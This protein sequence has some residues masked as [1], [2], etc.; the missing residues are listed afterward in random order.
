MAPWSQ[1]PQN[2]W[3]LLTS[4]LFKRSIYAG[5]IVSFVYSGNI[6]S[7][8]SC[9]P[10]DLQWWFSGEHLSFPPMLLPSLAA[11]LASGITSLYL[12]T[13]YID[14]QF[15]EALARSGA[16][17]TLQKLVMCPNII[18]DASAASFAALSQLR[19]LQFN[20][21]GSIGLLTLQSVAELPNIEVL[22]IF[23]TGLG[24]NVTARVLLAPQALPNLRKFICY[25]D[26]APQ[27]SFTM[28]DL[29]ALIE[30]RSNL[31]LIE[32]LHLELSEAEQNDARELLALHDLLPNWICFLHILDVCD[33]PEVFS[34]LSHKFERWR[35]HFEFAPTKTDD[36]TAAAAK[37]PR[38]K[39]WEIQMEHS[40]R[41]SIPMHLF[42]HLKNLN[43]SELSHFTGITWPDTLESL[44]VAVMSH[45][46]PSALDR[47]VDSLCTPALGKSLKDLSIRSFQASIHEGH[48]HK[49]LAALPNLQ[50]LAF[51]QRG[52]TTNTLSPSTTKVVPFSHPKLSSV[53]GLDGPE[54]QLVPCWT[55]SLTMLRSGEA[56]A[57][58]GK[59]STQTLANV[60]VFSM[61]DVTRITVGSDLNP[62]QLI[63]RLMNFNADSVAQMKNIVSLITD[64][65]VTLVELETMVKSL[66]LLCRCMAAVS[67]R[68]SSVMAFQHPR[69]NS[70]RLSQ[71]EEAGFTPEVTVD[72][73][74][75]TLPS[76]HRLMLDIPNANIS[77]FSLIGFDFLHEVELA[78]VPSALAVTIEQCER[79]S[80]ICFKAA[81]FKSIKMKD[82]PSL[83]LLDLQKCALVQGTPRTSFCASLPATARIEAHGESYKKSIQGTFED[84]IFNLK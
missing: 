2:L 66:P 47:L 10:R 82:L 63:L 7:I 76:L 43:L 16:A 54:M 62:Q 33:D 15:M 68:E 69:L 35:R 56:L 32:S 48:L 28:S 45:E 52:T 26:V 13:L 70:L 9:D 60:R 17:E 37:V 49:L 8:P 5:Y 39:M 74:A 20:D 84:V 61:D 51:G 12:C 19:E 81:S 1:V 73:S 57:E 6:D 71:R 34:K 50:C 75:D 59:I 23:Q 42:K 11:R 55:P 46:D 4:E 3:S 14:D 80:R 58:V 72:L 67:F 65:V 27:E 36:F 24:L 53:P 44:T 64:M 41:G 40:F 29:R 83:R 18:T 78:S 79:L 22:Q 30:K 31:E 77:N 21:E 25:E 38:V